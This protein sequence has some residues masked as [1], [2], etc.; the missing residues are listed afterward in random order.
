VGKAVSLAIL[1]AALALMAPFNTHAAGLGRLN[2]LSP[3]GQPLNAEI[4][5]VALRPGEEETLVARIAPLDAFTA[6]GIEPTAMLNT[7]R[8]ALER[9]GGQRILKV[10]TTAPVND[11]FVEILIELQWGSGRLVRE[12]TFL[13]DP[14]EY[15]ARDQIAAAPPAPKPAAPAPEAAKPP[16]PVEAKPIEP[17]APA[18][19]VIAPA[20][21]APEAAKEPAKEASAEPAKEPAKEPAAEAAKEPATEPVKEAAKP[22]AEVT[23]QQEV[24]KGDTVG[25]IA[26]ANL[27][28][29]ITLNQMLIAIYRANQDAFIRENVNLVRAGRI[30]NIPSAQE[31]GSV[32]A[33]EANR[34]VRAHMAEFR[35]YRSRLAAVPAAAET[36]PGQREGEGRIEPKPEAPKP[37]APADQVRLSKA[38]PQKPGAASQAARG[39]DAA[40]R[41]RALKEAQSRIGDL[42]KNVSDLQKLLELKNQQLAELEKKAGAKPA[43]APAPAAPTPP[44][45]VAKAPEAPK[46]E[47]AK[48]EAPKP[49]AAKPAAPAPTPAPAA[50]PAPKPAAP[51]PEPSLIDDFLDE[52][53]ALAGLGAVVLLLLVYAL[54]AW[55]KKKTA[56]ARFQDSVIGAAAAGA[57]AGSTL[58]EPTFAPTTGG[59][60]ATPASAAPA[61]AA[62]EEVDPIAEAD[63][64]MA[65]G[66]DAQAEEILKEALQKDSSRIPVHAK[67]LEIYANRK[68]ARSFE[69]TA[70]KL[71]GL[72]NSTG[73]EWDKAA[74]LGRSI[75]PGNGLYAGSGASGAA[76]AAAAAPVAAAAAPA[77]TLDF[78]IGG[79]AQ[80][81]ASAPDLT[82]DAGPKP[83]DTGLDFDVSGAS[84][85]KGPYTDET[86]ELRSTQ[87]KGAGG[88]DFNLDLGSPA[89]EAPPA[90]A[91]A[92]AADDPGL[93]FDLNLDL[94]G[95]QPEAPPP[96]ADLS[97]ISLDLGGAADAPAAAG[98]TDP[99]W[100][101]IATKLDLAKAYEEMGD[102]DGARELLNEV[103]KDG[104]AAQKGTAQQLLA[105]LG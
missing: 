99:K 76:L 41:E 4:E 91:S 47:A 15:K 48:P 59:S 28:P 69:Q 94:G 96:P 25:G 6:A 20:P 83:G 101:E 17:M 64:Y 103:M 36:V 9:R 55:R 62:A 63:V 14:P 53:V 79:A 51:A 56:Q 13:L 3:L 61:G 29:G 35:E 57:A 95:N 31:L 27:P 2:V 16:P 18:A 58:A 22:P 45:P 38:D 102:K 37:A 77:P 33:D 104:D 8:F 44:A 21:S 32:D 46:P 90:P 40:A 92:P 1:A 50:K 87:D 10:T 74:A 81:P 88:L 39:D 73:P 23:T 85:K 98:G 93:T 65:Y 60:A 80:G 11:P 49:E 82:L 84:Q 70:V 52:P 66:R 89:P 43:P 54:W 75:D 5:I 7:M 72:T 78:D 12:Y 19:P 30:L 34:L 105:K 86:L 97:S 68:D 26:R 42:E 71:K 24:K 100:Q 67:L